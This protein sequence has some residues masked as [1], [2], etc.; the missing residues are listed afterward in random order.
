MLL[1]LRSHEQ[2]IFLQPARRN[3]AEF[4]PPFN[5]FPRPRFLTVLHRERPLL[6]HMLM[7]TK[8]TDLYLR[9][10]EGTRRAVYACF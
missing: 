7:H 8:H 9:N 10:S 6:E 5:Q 1:C 2:N 4:R 3:V